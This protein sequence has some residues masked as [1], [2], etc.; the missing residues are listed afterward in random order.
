MVPSS[1]PKHDASYRIQTLVMVGGE[2]VQ[3]EGKYSRRTR[4]ERKACERDRSLTSPEPRP[5]VLATTLRALCSA[6]HDAP[7]ARGAG[8]RRLPSSARSRPPDGPAGL[9][10]CKAPSQSRSASRSPAFPNAM[11]RC[12]SAA[13]MGS[14]QPG[15]ARSEPTAS[16]A[17][18]R[19]VER[20]TCCTGTW[21]LPSELSHYP[22]Q[23]LCPGA[24]G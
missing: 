1:L 4:R 18:C 22:R 7:Y 16:N 8:F 3:R 2:R 15:V 24:G 5:R 14:S 23:R 6:S 21:V 20:V 9:T 10:A 11:M 19:V 17:V 12:A 13:R